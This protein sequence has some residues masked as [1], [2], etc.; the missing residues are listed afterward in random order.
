MLGEDFRVRVYDPSLPPNGHAGQPGVEFSSLS[1]TLAADVVF[2]CV[3]IS[4]F[5]QVIAEHVPI[6]NQ[7]EG[8]RTLIDVLSVK[9]HPKS[10]FEKYL[11]SGYQGLLTHPMFGPDS[12]HLNGLSGQPIVMDPFRISEQ[13]F[14]FWKRYFGD[15]Q[16]QV[17]EMSA[18]EHDRLAADSQGVTH[19]VGRILGEF[20]FKPTPIDTVGAKKLL[21]IK[22]QVCN[23]SWQLFV[24]L[25]TYNP[26]TR[27][28]RV[29]LSDA[30]A[31]IFDQLLPNRIYKDRLV[32]GI[33]GGRGSFNE[34]AARY[35]MSRTP[36]IAF[37]LQYLHTT[38]NVLR[39]LHE[40]IVE[41]GAIRQP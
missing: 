20:G 23:D 32:I 24:D 4:A 25:Q 27:L 5:E 37:E 7:L 30:Q 39:A 26:H 16:L 28:M 34:E 21:E 33:Q 8:K 15:K 18:D 14:H 36:E 29:R 22:T 2:Y 19:F 38:E 6:F 13:D 11:P 40:G 12:V 31:K 41:Q 9:L 1:E 3:P 10:V 35:Y 17:I